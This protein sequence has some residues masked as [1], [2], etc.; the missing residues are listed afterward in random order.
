MRWTTPKIL[1]IIGFTLIGVAPFLVAFL[2]LPD[3]EEEPLL[4]SPQIQPRVVGS[5]APLEFPFSFP[6]PL[7]EIAEPAAPSPTASPPTSVCSNRRDDDG[8]RKFDLA[9]PG[10]SSRNDNSEAPDPS[11][12]PTPIPSETPSTP[13]SPEPPAGNCN[14]NFDND[15]D[16]LPDGADPGCEDGDNNELPFNSSGGGGAPDPDCDVIRVP[17]CRT[18]TTTTIPEPQTATTPTTQPAT[19]SNPD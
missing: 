2:L 16:E 10:C 15:G 17:G 11:P 4:D 13:P 7:P 12:A 18:R 3:G 9:D 5:P 6:S 8:D 1:K 19:T 14:D